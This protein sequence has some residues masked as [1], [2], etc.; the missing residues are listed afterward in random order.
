M[1][2]TTHTMVTDNARI[3]IHRPILTEEERSRRMRLIEDAAINLILSIEN[4]AA[5]PKT[6]MMSAVL[7]AN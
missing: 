4:N 5:S 1:E 2:Y 6:Q 3:T 7:S